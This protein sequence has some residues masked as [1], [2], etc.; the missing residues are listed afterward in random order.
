M[1]HSH[2]Q[3][4]NKIKDMTI[5]SVF[6]AIITVISIIPTGIYILGIPLTLQT[7]AMAFSGYVLGW[8]KGTIAVVV[9]ILLG[10][11]GLPVFNG[12]NGGIQV[13]ASVVGGFILGFAFIALFAGLPIRFKIISGI[14]GIVL[15]HI[16]GIA[17]A[18]FFLETSFLSTAVVVSLPYIP[19]DIVSLVLAYFCAKSVKRSLRSANIEMN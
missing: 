19:K 3:T 4:N 17:V 8:K 1:K 16:L 10:A 7:F 13:I 9:Y 6:A 12:F 2:N 5:I 11:I 14:M 15:C 18:V